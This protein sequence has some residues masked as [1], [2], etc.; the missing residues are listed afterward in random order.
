MQANA[1]RAATAL[2]VRH[3]D[4]A[5]AWAR[6]SPEASGTAMTEHRLVATGEYGRQPS[7]SKAELAMSYCVNA[8]VEHPKVADAHA[9]VDCTAAEPKRCQLPTCYDPVLPFGQRP[10]SPFALAA[11]VPERVRLTMH[12]DV[13][14]TRNR[15]RP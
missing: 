4:L 13:K 15:I 3:V 5:A 9:I 12:G 8:A 1:G 6:E 10:N 2:R 14:D 11:R 7:A